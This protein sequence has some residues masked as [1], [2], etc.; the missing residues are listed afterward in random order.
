VARP[1]LLDLFCGAGGAAVGY[2]RAGFDVVGVDIEPQPHYPFEFIQMDALRALEVDWFDGS[3][4]AIHASPP[5]QAYSKALRH[6]AGP[7]PMLI[8]AV[9]ALLE[10][11][12]APWV[13]E[14]VAGSPLPDQA[15]LFGRNGVVLCGTSFGL[16][17]WRHRWFESSFPVR[18]PG[19]GH[20]RPAM[21]PHNVAGRHR[22]YAEYGR[23]DPEIIWR[24]EMG[25]GWMNKHEGREAIPPAY[26]EYIGAELIRHVRRTETVVDMG[27]APAG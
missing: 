17:V 25:V 27:G 24:Q 22:I 2:H 14:N 10:A 7:T 13:I 8:D 26:T 20:V 6:L 16:R 18:A 21:N 23:G 9:R 12:P 4:D 15:D 5:C 19:C 3:W 1:R 11:T